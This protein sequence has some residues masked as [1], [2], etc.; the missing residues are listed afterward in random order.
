MK[1]LKYLKY[2]SERQGA[3]T[4]MEL[5]I[6][7]A[8]IVALGALLFPALSQMRAH[9]KQAA[10]MSNL[11]S[12]GTA[13]FAVLQD[14]DGSFPNWYTDDQNVNHK[15]K[16]QNWVL[17][18]GYLSKTLRCPLATA[19]DLAVK[20]EGGGFHY[21][22]VTALCRWEYFKKPMTIPY[23][24]SRIVFA[25]EIYGPDDG[26]NS[27]THLNMTV[28]GNT[29]T[30]GE[31]EGKNR[32]V[33][34]HGSPERRC[35]NMLFLDGHIELVN[36]GPTKDWRTKYPEGAMATD[37]GGPVYLPAHIKNIAD[38]GYIK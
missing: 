2:R 32:S 8:I 22:G 4:L 16:F 1:K 21:A 23:P 11:K 38:F 13:L 3:F 10:C 17:D 25:V 18:K 6:A 26:L 28:W 35:L 14:F 12:Y 34:Y 36:P 33:Q 7:I 27:A 19:S 15:P 31:T 9:S 20:N 5:L 37:K 24:H 29:G 30:P